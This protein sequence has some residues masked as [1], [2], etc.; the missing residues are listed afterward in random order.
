MKVQDILSQIQK[1]LSVPK[2]RRNSFG[3]YNYR[4]CEDIVEG[5]KDLLPEGAAIKLTDNMVMLGDRFYIHAIASLS[6]N[7]E[8]IEASGFARESA[9]KKGMD[10]SQITG[11]ASSYARKYALNGLFAI[12]DGNDADSME[13]KAKPP[14]K[15]EAEKANDFVK[16]IIAKIALVKD[17]DSL[18]AFKMKNRDGIIKLEKGYPEL[19]EKL[20]NELTKKESELL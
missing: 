14:E 17:F 15:T 8:T 12:D 20:D 11:A 4:N 13:L 19:F 2:S 6:F 9:V 1:K 10:E 16:S 18:A 3:N 5:V 7:G